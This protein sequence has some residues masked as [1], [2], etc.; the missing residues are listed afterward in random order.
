MAKK[1]ID[2]IG[3]IAIIGLIAGLFFKGCSSGET[4]LEKIMIRDTIKVKFIDSI[5]S[6]KEVEVVRTELFPVTRFDT[7]TQN[8]TTYIEIPIEK[9][10]YVGGNDTLAWEAC[11]EG[12]RA[13]LMYVKTELKMPLY[14]EVPVPA[15]KWWEN[16]GYGPMAGV[17]YGLIGGKPDLYVGF[18]VTYNIGNLGKK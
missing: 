13:Q 6:I 17:G 15:P 11:V 14:Y 9:K 8:D 5:F 3:V 12:Y 18:G 4:H 2:I 16:F 7:I 1:I 10:V